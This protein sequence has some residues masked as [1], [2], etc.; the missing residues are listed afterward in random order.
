M[1]IEMTK[2]RMEQS[3]ERNSIIREYSIMNTNLS[4]R[5]KVIL[6]EIII[7][8]SSIVNCRKQI[9]MLIFFTIISFEVAL[10]FPITVKSMSNIL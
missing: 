8:P 6:S 1:A 2:P 9:F 4:Y 5:Q 10:D 7:D 3:F